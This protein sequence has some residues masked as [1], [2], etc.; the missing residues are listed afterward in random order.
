[1]A[2]KDLRKISKRIAGAFAMFV[3]GTYITSFIEGFEDTIIKGVAAGVV[4]FPPL[5]WHYSD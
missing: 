5:Y 1:M 2:Y 3:I 4:V